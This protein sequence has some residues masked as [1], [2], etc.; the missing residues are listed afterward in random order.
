MV[1]TNNLTRPYRSELRR[2]QA[3]ETRRQVIQG[4][5]EL[6]SRQGYKATTF[7][8]L[9]KHTGV[10]IETV[11]KHG[12]KAALLQSA[13]ELASFGID[14][15]TNF[16][17]T[18]FGKAMQHFGDREALAA[19]AGNA[20]LAINEPSAGVWMAV[21]GAAHGDEELREFQVRMLS[22]IRGQIERILRWVAE[23]DWLRLDVPF[24]E[25]VESFCIITCVESYVRFVV[26][27]GRSPDE[28]RAFVERTVR[29]T[30]LRP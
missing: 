20:M 9:A 28:Y 3:S 2:R 1:D 5:L 8:Q 22:S 17:E 19:F 16:F 14:G 24:D 7:A 4:A 12:P 26:L 6:F 15:E 25:L 30:I 18:E 11:Q 27:D 21:V 29:A 10:S 13:V 23:R